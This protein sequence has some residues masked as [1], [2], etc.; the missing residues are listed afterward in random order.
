MRNSSV[1]PYKKL[2]N[3]V[4]QGWNVVG[5]DRLTQNTYYLMQ[6]RSYEIVT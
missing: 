4:M 5:T 1:I 6:L 2:F 3:Y